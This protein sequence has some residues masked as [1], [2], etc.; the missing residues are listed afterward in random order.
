MI[1]E[2]LLAFGGQHTHVDP[3]TGLGLYGPYSLSGQKTP[4]LTSII[5]GIVGPPSMVGDAEQ[6]L[7]ACKGVLTN[8]GSEPFLHPHY[9]G[10]NRDSSFKCDLI[11]GDT[12]REAIRNSDMVAAVGEANPH[13]RLSR[14]IDLYLRQVEILAQRDP[15][16]H[17]ILIS[18]P[19]PG[20]GHHTLSTS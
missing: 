11:F 3:K 9:P 4:V 7:E 20:H 12:W 2:P 13:L 10:F 1:P 16:P 8:D 15:K 5:V 18:G 17:V 19:I 14:V 6:W